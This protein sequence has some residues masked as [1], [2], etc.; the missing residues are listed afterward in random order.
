M[1]YKALLSTLLSTLSLSLSLSASL[2]ASP[3]KPA[4]E[5]SP[6][7]DFELKDLKGKLVRL[8][9]YRGKVVLVNFWATWCAPCKQEIPHLNR[10]YKELKEQGFEVL[11]ISTDSPQTLSQV[12]R[13]ARR[14]AVHTLL[15]PEGR[16]VAQLNPRGVAPYTLI[17][18]PQGRAAFEH[19]GY[20]SGDELKM[21][22]AVKA[23][24]DEQKVKK[25]P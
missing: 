1:I 17:V 5:R 21:E 12:G 23:L 16:V 4:A 11:A 25:A 10:L 20:T 3:L 18:D 14:W 19:D 7:A 9:D 2:W 15:D 13:L 8:S 6:V 22:S 24:L